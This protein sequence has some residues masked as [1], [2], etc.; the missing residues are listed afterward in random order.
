MRLIWFIQQVRGQLSTW[1]KRCDGFIAF[2]TAD[3]PDILAVKLNLTDHG[4]DI[5]FNIWRKVII[6]WEYV[7]KRFGGTNIAA[8]NNRYSY[9][10]NT[11]TNRSSIDI[12]IVIDIENSSDINSYDWFLIGGDD[13]YVAVH[14]LR[15]H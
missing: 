14:N 12:N 2:S 8:N 7:A 15:Y 10:N 4:G 5:Y 3:D 6:M 13:L 11:N 9:N 1:A